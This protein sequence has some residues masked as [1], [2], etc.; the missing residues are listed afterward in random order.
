MTTTSRHLVY[1]SHIIKWS[2][3]GIDFMKSLC[4]VGSSITSSAFIR[5]PIYGAH[6]E[7]Q[8]H[9]CGGRLPLLACL[10]VSTQRI[11]AFL[12]VADTFC[13][14]CGDLSVF[15]VLF[16]HIQVF[17]TCSAYCAFLGKVTRLTANYCIAIFGLQ[18]YTGMCIL[19]C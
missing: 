13:V 2:C 14:R 6:N 17:V 5:S 1:R 16:D 12:F 11:S 4:T 3:V 15:D 10:K 19:H 7:L 18:T 9:P 8:S